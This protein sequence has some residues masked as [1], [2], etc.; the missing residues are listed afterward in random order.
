MN[1]ITSFLKSLFEPYPANGGHLSR[2]EAM[3]P[4]SWRNDK[5]DFERYLSY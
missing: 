1:A 3:Q 2:F 5:L 4:G